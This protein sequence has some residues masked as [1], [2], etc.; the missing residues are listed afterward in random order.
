MHRSEH[1]KNTIERASENKNKN[2]IKLV[3]GRQATQQKDEDESGSDLEGYDNGDEQ[4]HGKEIY[5]SGRKQCTAVITATTM[6]RRSRTC[7]LHIRRTDIYSTPPRNLV[8]KQC[9]PVTSDGDCAQMDLEK[10]SQ[11]NDAMD[12]TRQTNRRFTDSLAESTF[13]AE[14][15]EE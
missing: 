9:R 5:D 3:L 7:T 11:N 10:H 13:T 6:R 1:P 15:S 8:R 14:L 2:Q 4:P 12:I